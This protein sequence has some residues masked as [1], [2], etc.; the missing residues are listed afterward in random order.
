MMAAGRAAEKG[1]S[2]L[3]VEKNPSLGRKLLISGGG[4]CNFTNA[5]ADPRV[6]AERYGDAKHALLSPFS[7]FPPAEVMEWFARRGM[8]YKVEANQRAFPVD[9]S[10]QSVLGVLE[11]YLVEG[12]VEVRRGFEVTGFE[13]ESEKILAVV[14]RQGRLRAGRFVLA[15]G[16][17]SR[18]ETGST[19]DGF[20]WLKALGLRVRFPEPSLVPVAFREPW[21]ADLAGLALSD[22]GIE[23]WVGDERLGRQ[24]GKLLFTHFGLSGPVVLNFATELSRWRSQ[25][26]RRGDLILK[27]DLFPDVD[28][29]DLD[30]Q[31]VNLFAVQPGKKLKNALGTLVAP[32]L[33]GRI[34]SSGNLDP[35]KSLAQVTRVE[36][37]ALGTQLKGFPF[38][39]KKLMDESRA[40]VS[41]GG[42]HI[43]EVDWRTM[44]CKKIPNLAVTGD[45]LDINR[46]SGGFSLQL[47]WAT[48]R[49][50]G[51]PRSF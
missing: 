47:C 25:T 17:T 1:E 16:G 51:E 34:L 37:E 38:T 44:S 23:A 11:R 3:L 14:G 4:R 42:L 6:L 33:V 10:A 12:K 41:S 9:D 26:A 27:L 39:F 50:A 7:K 19:G 49:V 46:P 24:R 43:E 22:A 28:S 2:V 15:T 40:V 13:A 30:R 32:R 45:L 18:P 20:L 29:R 31:L 8:P 48:G 5:E 21:V 35:D 36:R